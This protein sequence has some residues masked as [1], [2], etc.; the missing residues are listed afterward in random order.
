[1][2]KIEEILIDGLE[3]LAFDSGEYVE[4]EKFAK[5]TVFNNEEGLR[6]TLPD[7]R[8]FKIKAEQI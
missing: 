8:E 2:K 6:I 1:M 4:I 3:L 5:Q 7:G